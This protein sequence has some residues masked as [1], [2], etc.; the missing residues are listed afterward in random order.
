METLN[1]IGK[2]AQ[3]ICMP[4]SRTEDTK[5]FDVPTTETMAKKETETAVEKVSEKKIMQNM[6]T[7]DSLESVSMDDFQELQAAK[8]HEYLGRA[9]RNEKGGPPEVVVVVDPYSTGKYLVEELRSRSIQMVAVRSSLDLAPFWLKSL[10]PEYFL[11]V[12]DFDEHDIKSTVELFSKYNV[13]HVVPGSEPG[14][15]VADTLADALGC[16]WNGGDTKE[17]RR[18]KFAMQERIRSQGLRA[19]RQIY[20]D[21]L[22]EM[23]TWCAEHGSWP[24]VVK[25]AMSGGCDGV[26]F[27]KNFGEVEAAVNENLSVMNVN[28]A[29]NDKLLLQECLMGDEYIVDMVS[30][31]GVHV[32]SGIWRYSKL[33]LPGINF[34]HSAAELLPATGDVQDIL[35][36]YVKQCLDALHIAKGASHSEVMMTSSGPCLIETGARMHGLKGPKVLQ[37]ATGTYFAFVIFNI[38]QAILF[39]AVDAWNSA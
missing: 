4:D 2:F 38:T 20:S 31:D 16:P 25:P 17:W 8:I 32:V 34:Q 7:V 37:I 11:D 13:K 35:V 14:V 26:S 28:G 24:V 10:Q 21:D 1:L 22:N 27:C 6:S 9:T 12:I 29:V 3:K 39:R 18:H 33:N 23:A 30:N 19:I 36:S 15:M 5:R